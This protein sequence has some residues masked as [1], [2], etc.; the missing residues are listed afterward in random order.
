MQKFRAGGRS[1]FG[2]KNQNYI[3]HFGIKILNYLCSGKRGAI[4]NQPVE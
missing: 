1:A 2:R 4:K 3:L